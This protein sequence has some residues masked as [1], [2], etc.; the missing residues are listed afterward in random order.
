[1][2]RQA[3]GCAAAATFVVVL[4][5]LPFLPGAHDPLAG[6]LSST[7]R[8]GGGVAVLLAPFG[9]MWMARPRRGTAIATLA[10]FCVVW[11]LV[12]LVGFM[13][14]GFSLCAILLLVG[15]FL[16][17]RLRAALG[18]TARSA[19]L[20]LIALPP[21]VLLLQQ[22]LLGRAVGFSRDLAI[23]N[24]APLIADIERYRAERGTYPRSLLSVWPD[25]KP[26]VIGIERY[27]YEPSGDAYNVAFEQIARDLATREF[28]V[29]N[30]RDQ[31]VFTSHAMDLLQYPPDRLQRSRGYFGVYDTAHPH[32]KS[33]WFD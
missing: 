30:P 16:F 24:A 27:H 26:G 8:I 2:V 6:P 11:S 33:F 15:A 1:M 32:W 3:A 22:T 12:S 17:I 31:Q 28:V 23:A 5:L 25:Y 10:A 7:A 18:R 21:T 29:Y 20:Y 9:A 4:T 19:G 14:T 13:T